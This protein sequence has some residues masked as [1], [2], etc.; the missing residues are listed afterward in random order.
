MATS[1]I[2][3]LFSNNKWGEYS[4]YVYHNGEWRET[5]TFLY[6]NNEWIEFSTVQL[7][8]ILFDQGYIDGIQWERNYFSLPS[9]AVAV[10]GSTDPSRG[11]D[12]LAT[13][14][15]TKNIHAY[16]SKHNAAVNFSTLIK[17]PHKANKINF[18][19]GYFYQS[20][21][22][23][24]YPKYQVG[25]LHETA[26]TMVDTEKGGYLTDEVAL[27]GLGGGY[28]FTTISVST[29]NFKNSSNYRTVINYLGSDNTGTQSHF[30]IQKVWF[31]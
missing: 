27:S 15:G 4:P 24:A 9:D 7:P 8:F 19:L 20:Y 29:N 31:E 5:A 13:V 14:Q 3:Q 12:G 1:G 28:Q 11:N 23:R 17:I 30:Y 25:F 2:I 16:A 22:D 21:N 18:T 6:H 26:K 10:D